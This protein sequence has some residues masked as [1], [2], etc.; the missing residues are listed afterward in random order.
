V[1]A[2]AEAK[3]FVLPVAEVRVASA[4]SGSSRRRRMA[5]VV[6]PAAAALNLDRLGLTC[7]WGG[8]GR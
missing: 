3:A 7:W 5:A 8:G 4:G 6:L 1:L 2:V